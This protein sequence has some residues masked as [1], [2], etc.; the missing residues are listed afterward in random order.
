MTNLLMK[1]GSKMELLVKSNDFRRK[2]SNRKCPVNFKRPRAK[3]S[4][5]NLI[6]R[7]KDSIH[8]FKQFILHNSLDSNVIYKVYTNYIF[9]HSLYTSTYNRKKC[10]IF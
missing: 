8:I 5:P 2:Y 9:I 4:K 3:D 6:N 1:I 7:K 10:E